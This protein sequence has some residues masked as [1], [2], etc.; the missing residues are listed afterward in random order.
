MKN[1][2]VIEGTMNG[3]TNSSDIMNQAVP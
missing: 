1:M 3:T 2:S